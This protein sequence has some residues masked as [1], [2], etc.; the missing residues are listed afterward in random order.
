MAGKTYKQIAEKHGVTYNEVL[1]LVKKKQWKRESNLSKVKKG[2]QNAKGNKGGPGAEKRNTRAL[3]TGE[4]ETI[5]DDLL[6]DE[7]KALLKQIELDDKKY[8][9]ISEIKILSIRE[10]RILN[11]IQDLQNGKEMSIVRM[12]KSS[13]NNVSYRDNGTLTTT[14]AESTL[15]IVQ[16]L[17]EALTRVQEAKR[18]YIDSYHKI[19]TDDRKLELDLIRLE[20][21]AARDDSSNTEDM[22]DDSF[23]KALNDSTEGAWNDYTEEE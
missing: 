1:Y 16:R 3:K 10:R 12:S 2:N 14:E 22:K 13:S 5:Y 15:N 17:E 4:Y 8:Q 20:M 7:E 11:K 21:E 9:I 19:E 18:R 23:I 6:T